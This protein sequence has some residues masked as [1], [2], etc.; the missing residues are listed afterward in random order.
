MSIEE[1]QQSKNYFKRLMKK[2]KSAV[3]LVIGHSEVYST[4]D[5]GGDLKF[6]PAIMM[7]IKV[8]FD[9]EFLPKEKVVKLN[10]RGNRFFNEHKRDLRVIN[11]VYVVYPGEYV[12]QFDVRRDSGRS[13]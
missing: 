11:S 4:E 2:A 7:R 10:V 6:D 8:T 9:K 5:S 1:G 12:I 3:N 13:L